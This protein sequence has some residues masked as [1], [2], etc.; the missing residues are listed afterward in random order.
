MASMEEHARELI[1]APKHAHISFNLDTR[2]VHFSWDEFP[3]CCRSVTGTAFYR[4]IPMSDLDADVLIDTAS[5]LIEIAKEIREK[6]D[7]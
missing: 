2:R 6:E 4:S 7:K 5:R 3:E 1:A